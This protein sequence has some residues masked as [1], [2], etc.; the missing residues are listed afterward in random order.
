MI[1]KIYY[2]NGYSFLGHISNTVQEQTNCPSCD[3]VIG[4]KACHEVIPPK[5][6]VSVP[7]PEDRKNKKKVPISLDDEIQRQ[8]KMMNTPRNVEKENKKSNP[9][10]SS[11]LFCTQPE[12]GDFTFL[13]PSERN[14]SKK[15]TSHKENIDD[16]LLPKTD[17]K[18]SDIPP[19][20][21]VSQNQE[22]RKPGTDS[23][24]MVSTDSKYPAYNSTYVSQYVSNFKSSSFGG[25]QELCKKTYDTKELLSAGLV[26]RNL[27]ERHEEEMDIDI[28]DVSVRQASGGLRTTKS[29]KSVCSPIDLDIQYDNLAKAR[30]AQVAVI[31]SEGKENQR[32]EPQIGEPSKPD[33]YQPRGLRRRLCPK[34]LIRLNLN[35]KFITLVSVFVFM[36]TLKINFK[37]YLNDGKYFI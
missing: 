23:S 19:W 9:L 17:N 36:H 24:V 14:I 12:Q 8:M 11:K 31:K 28:A 18:A 16:G 21:K 7:K 29:S 32:K 20:Q 10:V 30:G 37:Q 13:S 33:V 4:M 26:E 3:L 5:L 35:I 2:K 34:G 22:Y 15:V 25:N 6:I 27:R 1:R